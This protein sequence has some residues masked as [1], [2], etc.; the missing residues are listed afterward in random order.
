MTSLTPHY[1]SLLFP[2]LDPPKISE[3]SRAD[4]MSLSF[5]DEEWPI[6]PGVPV[7]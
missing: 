3:S 2:E 4:A 6:L 1:L 7:P 5:Y